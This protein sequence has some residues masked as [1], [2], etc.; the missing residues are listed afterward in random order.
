[1]ARLINEFNVRVI[2]NLQWYI[3]QL[4]YAKKELNNSQELLNKIGISSYGG[5]ESNICVPE[6][7]HRALFI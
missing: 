1:M 7:M 4:K 6:G 5:D 2:E 3:G